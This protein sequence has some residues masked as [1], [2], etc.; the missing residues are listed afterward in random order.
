MKRVD[1]IFT[2]IVGIISLVIA[3]CYLANLIICGNIPHVGNI[4]MFSIP[5]IIIPFEFFVAI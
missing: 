1:K 3:A 4:I 2:R 5:A